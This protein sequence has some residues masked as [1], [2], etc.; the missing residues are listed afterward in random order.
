MTWK[1]TGVGVIRVVLV[2]PSDFKNSNNCI[3]KIKSKPI[4][5]Y[6]VFI[7]EKDLNLIRKEI[8]TSE[9]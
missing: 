6:P 5:L 3:G 7:Q 9:K 2:S 4:R 1:L 8:I